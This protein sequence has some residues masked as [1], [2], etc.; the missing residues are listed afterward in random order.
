MFKWAD[1]GEIWEKN[2]GHPIPLGGIV[3]RRSYNGDL[4][5]KINGIINR[6][7]AYAFEHYTAL[8]AFITENAQEMDE[9]VMRNHIG[10]Y[11]NEFSLDLSNAGRAAV[12][13]LLELSAVVRQAPVGGEF[14]VFL[15]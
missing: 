8:P 10:L 11:V 5:K 6:S 3:A 7:L 9:A 15:D 2:T 13:K 14:E 4:L 12:W 1:L